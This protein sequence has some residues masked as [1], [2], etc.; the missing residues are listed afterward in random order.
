MC[1][2]VSGSGVETPAVEG[3]SPVHED[4]GGVCGC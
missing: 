1:C 4:H 3:E 2:V